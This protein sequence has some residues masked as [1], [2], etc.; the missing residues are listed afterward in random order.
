ML[1]ISLSTLITSSRIII[2]VFF[3]KFYSIL[4]GLPSL[5]LFH[6]LLLQVNGFLI[7]V[8]GHFVWEN[9][10]SKMLYLHIFTHHTAANR[11]IWNDSV[12]RQD[13]SIILK[14]YFYICYM[15]WFNLS[16]TSII[17]M[18]DQKRG[19]LFI[20]W[21]QFYSVYKIQM[22]HWESIEIVTR[23]A[24][25]QIVTRRASTEFIFG[26]LVSL[27]PIPSL[28]IGWLYIAESLKSYLSIKNESFKTIL[29]SLQKQLE[30]WD[31][32]WQYKQLKP[33]VYF[34]SCVL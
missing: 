4:D 32:F 27:S 5:C 31:M 17:W 7:W 23:I 33:K 13:L 19:W 6:R 1:I 20:I 16:I 34:T 14:K 30:A 15:E 26:I 10:W 3:C 21:N 9:S 28:P 12:L 22:L 25:I 2:H 8:N 29:S 11:S 18:E 24:S